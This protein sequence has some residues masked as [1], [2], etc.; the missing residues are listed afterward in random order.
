MKPLGLIL[1]LVLCSAASATAKD[2]RGI[3]PL[4]STRADVERMLGQPNTNSSRFFSSYDLEEEKILIAFADDRDCLS[5][6]APDTVLLIRVSPTVERSLA[7]YNFDERRFRKFTASQATALELLG[8]VNEEEGLVIRTR[9]GIV[10]EMVYI[11]SAVDRPR[12]PSPYSDVERFAGLTVFRCGLIRKFDEYGDIL[13]SDE[14]ARL[15]NFAITLENLPD[16]SAHLIVYA[17]RKALVAEAQQRGNR[18]R[19]YL[20][21]V[22]G[23]ESSR[24]TVVDA[25][26]QEDLAVQLYVLPPGVTPP[27]PYPTVAAKDVEILY[28]KP[29]RRSRRN[30]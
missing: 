21:N 2:W 6:V 25:G 9:K 5:S 18:A 22:R 24:V 29:K 20:V 8:L 3:L 27:E 19:D 15:D 23:I 28:E 17:G 26:H 13:F 1:I 30:R 11:A 7:Q 4:H 10:E 14:K 12:C 16:H